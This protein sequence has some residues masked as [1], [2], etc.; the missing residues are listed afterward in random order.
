ML[1]VKYLILYK[2][3]TFCIHQKLKSYN[4]CLRKLWFLFVLF[5]QKTESR[6]S[7]FAF[8]HF[9]NIQK[10]LF[11]SISI[12]TKI[13]VAIAFLHLLIPLQILIRMQCMF[14]F[15]LM[16]REP[17]WDYVVLDVLPNRSVHLFERPSWDGKRDTR[18][19]YMYLFATS[20]R[21]SA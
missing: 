19:Y 5:C 1:F 13:V 15:S 3:I 20:E 17:L 12:Y 21:K 9:W 4:E 6:S 18:L 2:A 8:D 7:K 10:I 14:T 16:V 11:G